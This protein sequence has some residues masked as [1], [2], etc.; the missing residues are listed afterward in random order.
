MKNANIAIRRSLIGQIG[1]FIAGAGLLFGILNFIWAGVFT[2]FIV[3]AV[4]ITLLGLSLWAIATPREFR[5]FFTGR[6]AQ[7]GTIAVFGTLLLIGIVALAYIITQREVITLDITAGSRFTLSEQ[8]RQIIKRIE[9]S[10]RTVQITGFYAAEQL[11][12]REVDDQYWRLYESESGGAI[13]RVY[14]DP[15]EEPALASRFSELLTQGL[16]VF[17]SFLNED[18]SIDI[19][20]LQIVQRGTSQ[21]RDM[22][23]ALSRLLISGTLSVY[24]ERGLG[25]PD[26]LDD[27]AQGFSAVNNIVQNNGLITQP[28]D[29]TQLAASS[30]DI[31]SDA[32]TVIIAR[33]ARRMTPAEVDVIDRYLERGGA[34]LILADIFYSTEQFLDDQDPF[35]SYL[36]E[37]FG[38][39][40]MMSVVVDPGAFSGSELDIV[41]AAVFTE[42]DIG[43]Q[44]NREDDPQSATLFHIARPIEV[45]D[46][47]PVNNGRIIMSSP[48]SW[49]ETDFTALF[50]RN[51]YRQEEND[52]V[53][54]LTTVAWAWDQ[55]TD[56][57][58]LLIGDS[59]FATNG[60][61]LSPQGN[62][63]LLFDGLGW[64]TG[65]TE[66]VRFSFRAFT[67][68][69]PLLF[70]DQS[71]LNTVAF[72]TIILMPGAMLV[73][74][75]G[76]WL[77]RRG[78]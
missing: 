36:W 25:G 31:P 15:R 6:Q 49:G 51:E 60:R 43:A 40:P 34:L 14:I 35:N 53:G 70:V 22:S 27:S 48:M 75:L 33:A 38:L 59:D 16:N 39:R 11:L 32:S 26:P 50:E 10:G 30:G 63:L 72:I 29:L 12:Q 65:F 66:Q 5:D 78:R 61:I 42:V 57:K 58:I 19:N 56:A 4:L 28:L 44:L 47:P 1:S 67:E 20:S 9:Q 21:E 2:S 68:G 23:E 54:P 13:H 24:F 69:L 76:L 7:R 55:E 17:V 46:D 71:I 77:R 73:T 37:K 18:G 3:I 74:A 64:L 8:T 52:L 62:S 41:S 45:D